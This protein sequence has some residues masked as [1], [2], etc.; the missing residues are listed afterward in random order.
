M[1]LHLQ[2]H[3]IL[4]KF[5]NI[6]GIVTLEAIRLDCENM[7]NHIAWHVLWIRVKSHIEACVVN[8]ALAIYL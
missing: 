5:I 8:S 2:Q 6:K 3:V 7:Y 1:L 4:E